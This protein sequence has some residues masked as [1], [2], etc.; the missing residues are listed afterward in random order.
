GQ[1]G[2]P[3]TPDVDD[4]AGG[5]VAAGFYDDE[6]LDA[7]YIAG[8]GRVNENIGLTAVHHIFHAEHNRLVEHTKDVVLASN[9]VAFINEWLLTPIASLPTTPGAIAAL[10]WNGERLFQTAKFGTEMQYQHLVFEEFARTIQPQIDVFTGPTQGYDADIDAAIVAEFA[11]T[12]YRFG[13]SMLTETLD[14]LDSDFVNSEI[15]LIAAFLNPLAFVDSGPTPDEAAG[16]LARGLTRQT[17]N[18]I[19]EFVTEALRNNLV[20]LP[21][22]LAAINIAR[23]RDTGIPSFNAARREFYNM[24]GD[25]QLKPYTSWVDLLQNLKHPASLINFIAAYGTHAELLAVDVDTMA[26]KRAVATALVMGGDALINAGTPEERTFTA[27]DVD[28]L[29]FLNSVGAY[30]SV[31]GITTTGVDDI[32]FWIGGLAEAIMPFGGMLGSTFN[33]VFETQLEALQNGDRFYYLDRTAGLNF[34]TE[35]ENNSFAKMVMNN[36][37]A[38]H[39]PGLIFLKQGL[40]LEADQSLQ[41]NEE[42]GNADPLGDVMRDDPSTAGVEVNYLHYTG[43]EHV[44]LGGTDGNDTL[45]SSIGDDTLWGDAGNDR[46]EGGHGNDQIRGGSGH[47][48]ITDI[49]GDDNIQGDDGNDVIQSGNGINLNLGGFGQDFIINGEDS[50]ETFGG[51]GND[52]ILGSNADEQNAGNE[53]DD[54]LE[55]GHLDGSPGDNFDPLGLDTV[56]GND[57]YIGS[58]QTDIMNSEGG[59]DIMVGSAGPGDKYLG[60]SGFDW[61]TFKDDVTGVE[62]DLT[63]RAIDTAPGPVA[64]GILAR[65]REV[66]GLSGSAHSDILHGDDADAAVIATA[67]AQGSVLTNIALIDGLQALLDNAM[68][69]PVTSFGAGNIILGGD[70]SDIIEGRA[71]DDIID[72]DKWLNVRISVRAGIDANGLPTGPEIATYDSMRPLVPLMLSGFYNPGQ[73]QI[74]REILPGSGGFNF[75]TAEFSGLLSDYTVVETG[76]G[77]YM[78]I[79]NVGTDGIDRLSG[80]ERLQFNDQSLVL[81]DGL[82]AEAVGLASINDSTPEVGSLLVAGVEGVTD[83]DNPGLGAVTGPVSYYWQA[84]F[85]GA[86][87]FEDIIVT[88]GVG[89]EFATGKSYRVTED[90]AGLALRVKAVYKDANG[91]LET[92]FSAV[93]APISA[94]SVNDAPVGTMLI[95]DTTPNVGQQ[96]TATRAFTDPDG[97]ANPVLAY[98]WQSGN[99]G[100]FSN[101]AGA[102]TAIFTPT[103][104]LAGQQLRVRV[105]YTDELGTLETVTSLATSVVTNLIV[106][107]AGNDVLNGTAVADE[108]QGLGGNDILNGL[109]GDDVLDGGAGNDSLIGHLGNDTLI[110]GLGNDTYYVDVSGDVIVEAVGGGTDTVFSSSATYT[111]GANVE[112]L[113]HFGVNATV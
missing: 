75:D 112:N 40:I 12:V 74:V 24:T 41:F 108:I 99:G 23:G 59:D 83:A 73:L 100:V 43:D 107:T 53:G 31:G 13:H 67:G 82:N 86:G 68:G 78:V 9:D 5:P 88:T 87:V 58:G 98:Q 80:I 104:A 34:V 16:A 91:V 10:D 89:T 109:G 65:F 51:P 27:D 111:L 29:N 15:G 56:I 92:V 79:D 64:A 33:F 76:P 70:G 2:A 17:G 26:E 47:D 42:L 94:V 81:V 103:M 96:L 7:H 22:D 69:A 106:G 54:W 45:I 66:E 55:G 30:A 60:A 39:L 44:V 14:R 1:T 97:P 18:A 90:L 46:L 71:G 72:G 113:T 20:G 63:V 77:N 57:V 8:D 25:S 105:T 48:I 11:H 36:T 4:V 3:L 50:T 35:L 21:L 110:G 19:D 38:T 101:I 6:L 84:D 95:S 32:D 102:T 62:I 52:F 93:T 85:D 61:A 28:R 49:G 37:S